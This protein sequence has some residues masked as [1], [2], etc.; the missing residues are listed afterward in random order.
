MGATVSSTAAAVRQFIDAMV[1]TADFVGT[2]HM[3]LF[4]AITNTSDTSYRWNVG[5]GDNLSSTTY[6]EGDAISAAGNSLTA[7]CAIAMA[8]NMSRTIFSVTGHAK[9][10]AKGGY[11][12]I[13]SHEAESG[14]NAHQHA[15][16][17]ILAAQLEAAIDASGTYAGQ[18]RATVLMA[19]Y[20]AAVATLALSDLQTMYE[21][22]SKVEIVADM[23]NHILM[24][25]IDMVNEYMDVASGVQYNEFNHIP[26]TAI[27]AGKLVKAPTYNNMPWLILPNMTATSVLCL[28]PSDIQRIIYRPVE[29]EQLAKTK[30]E[31]VYAITSCELIVAKNPRK[32]GKLT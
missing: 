8:T 20:E 4:P 28:N 21:T 26:G 31:D 3:D 12:D 9:A 16:D 2:P 10:A 18:T 6:S 1:N 27:D 22:L 24:S 7:T 25:T 13:L 30:D 32:A 29:V 11:F 23:S 14:L 15:M 5:Y 17:D 19:A